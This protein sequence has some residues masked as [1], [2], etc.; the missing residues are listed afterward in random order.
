MKNCLFI[1]TAIFLVMNCT[2][3]EKSSPT[4]LYIGTYT[5]GESEGVY[6]ALFDTVT[7]NLSNM[8]LVAEMENPSFV[9]LSPDNKFLYAVEETNSYDELGGAVFAFAV[10]DST[11]QLLNTRG[12]GGAHPCHVAVSPNGATVAVSNYTGGNLA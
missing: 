12:T 1:L 2:K 8:T 7:G 11:L 10:S 3:V 6:R 5:D 4:P 9:K